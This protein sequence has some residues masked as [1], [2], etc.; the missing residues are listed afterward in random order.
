M[1]DPEVECEGTEQC[2][3]EELSLLPMNFFEQHSCTPICSTQHALLSSL[4][5]KKK[6]DVIIRNKP[7]C[8]GMRNAHDG[9]FY[10]E[11][12]RADK[13]PFFYTDIR[14]PFAL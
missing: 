11:E 13:I 3:K 6:D 9:A 4:E 5:A 7:S 2:C 1:F 14:T 8:A 12:K 10:K